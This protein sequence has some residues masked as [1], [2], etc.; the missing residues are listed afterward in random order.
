MGHDFHVTTVAEAVTRLAPWQP[1][2]MALYIVAGVVFSVVAALRCDDGS[3]R[4]LVAI[5]VL[6]MLAHA[7]GVAAGRERWDPARRWRRSDPGASS[8]E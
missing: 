2:P 8:A 7:A 4:D 1:P 5:L 3:L 6:A